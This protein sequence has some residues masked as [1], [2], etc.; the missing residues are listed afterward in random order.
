MNN[1]AFMLDDD[2]DVRRADLVGYY[3]PREIVSD[4]SLTLSR[5]R[6]LLAYWLSDVNAVRGAPGLRRSTAG[7]TVSVD[8]LQA[9]LCQLDQM[10]DSVPPPEN[11]PALFA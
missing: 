8:Q 1:P 6:A 9:A 2:L 11:A 7:V 3:H 4:A 5:R 10:S